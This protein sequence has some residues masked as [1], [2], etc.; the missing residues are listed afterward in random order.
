VIH[1]EHH[2]P[3][4]C[5][6]PTDASLAGFNRF[7]SVDYAVVSAAARLAVLD[8]SDNKIKVV[9]PEI[10]SL[11]ELNTLDLSNNDIGGGSM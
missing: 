11:A 5:Q 4:R 1:R 9:G 10:G 6:V 2:C 8:L 7:T 3:H